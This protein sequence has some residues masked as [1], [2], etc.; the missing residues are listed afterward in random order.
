MGMGVDQW[1]ADATPS[2]HILPRRQTI[3]RLPMDITLT[4]YE[5]VAVERQ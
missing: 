2:A 4:E 3:V 1:C 5:R